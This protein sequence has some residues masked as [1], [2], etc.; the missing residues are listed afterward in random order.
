[1]PNGGKILEYKLKLQKIM[2]KNEKRKQ[3]FAII[4]AKK[5]HTYKRVNLLIKAFSIKQCSHFR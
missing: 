4:M 3:I 1:M 2:E 5:R